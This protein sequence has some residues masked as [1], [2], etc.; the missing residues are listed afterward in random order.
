MGK[1]SIVY[2]K[3]SILP[4]MVYKSKSDEQIMINYWH[5]LNFKYRAFVMA[6]IAE[7]DK[8]I[9]YCI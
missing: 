2:L 6:Q 5:V 3:V 9:E 4:D 8:K 7:S 1:V